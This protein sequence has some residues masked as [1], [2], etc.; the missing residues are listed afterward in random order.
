[1][2]IS[3]QSCIQCFQVYQQ[4]STHCLLTVTVAELSYVEPELREID[5]Y[6]DVAVLL[7]PAGCLSS[8][9]HPSLCVG[10]ISC[11]S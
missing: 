9:I 10:H 4:S 6:A 5:L 2:Q 7:E 1:M 11:S 3:V 8:C